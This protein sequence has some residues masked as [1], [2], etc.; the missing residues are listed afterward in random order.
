MLCIRDIADLTFSLTDV[1]ISSIITSVP[2]SLF[3]MLYIL[4]VKLASVVL[5]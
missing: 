2:Q 4:L 1:S 3:C 5:V